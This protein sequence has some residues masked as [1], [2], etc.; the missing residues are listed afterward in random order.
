LAPLI[1]KLREAC[2]RGDKQ[3]LVAILERLEIGYHQRSEAYPVDQSF[4]ARRVEAPQ[5]TAD[6]AFVEAHWSDS[7]EKTGKAQP[8]DT[9]ILKNTD[10]STR[11][12]ELEAG[13]KEPIHPFLSKS[14]HL[15][16]L[17]TRPLTLGA[18]GIVLNNER[19]VLLVRHRY[20]QGWQLPGGGVEIGE[21]PIDALRRE[22]LEEAG[23]EL[24]SEPQLL[25]SYHNRGVSDRDHV[26]VYRCEQSRQ[27]SLERL[28]G[29]IAASG[30]F[31]I[32]KLPQ[33]TTPGTKRR[34]AECFE[35]LA[36]QEHW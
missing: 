33:D 21:S 8:P 4:D 7:D 1:E 12:S 31:P 13:G 17:L 20:E 15:F 14:L 11:P 35:G 19:E 2:R 29:E 16:F 18:R 24:V 26:L 22:V 9:S 32:D 28:S 23:I 6:G 34:L 30:F 27:G 36:V 5:S 10:T 3:T 25:G